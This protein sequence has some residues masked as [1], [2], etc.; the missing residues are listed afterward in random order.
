MEENMTIK[1][2][3]RKYYSFKF[4]IKFAGETEDV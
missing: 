3:I 2:N 4:I 1:E